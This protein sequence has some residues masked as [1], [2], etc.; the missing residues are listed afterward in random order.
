VRAE[1]FGKTGVRACADG[2]G[3]VIIGRIA[4]HGDDD[5]LIGLG[6][7]ADL[8]ADL[9]AV[10][11][12]QDQV[13]KDEMRPKTG[14]L[15]ASVVASTG[16]FDRYVLFGQIVRQLFD[17]RWLVVHDE[18]AELEIRRRLILFMPPFL[19]NRRAPSCE[20]IVD[21]VPPEEKLAIGPSNW[22]EQTDLNPPQDG[23]RSNTEELG[24]LSDRKNICHDNL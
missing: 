13:E 17:H 16:A 1:R 14:D 23:V 7:G 6:I 9:D 4:G 8:L 15:L 11:S 3:H 22:I 10:H 19:G 12:R 2:A 24:Y 18:N 20:E 5:D 21:V